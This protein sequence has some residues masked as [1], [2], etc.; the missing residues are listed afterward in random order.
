M[1]EI[2][3]ILKSLHELEFLF[4]YHKHILTVN[5]CMCGN[6]MQNLKEF[7]RVYTNM[8]DLSTF[9]RKEICKMHTENIRLNKLN[10]DLTEKLLHF[11]RSDFKRY[12]SQQNINKVNNYE[13][14]LLKNTP[15][16]TTI[17]QA[18]EKTESK[19][20][21]LK[22]IANKADL[23]SSSSFA[24][25]GYGSQ[26]SHLQNAQPTRIRSSINNSTPPICRQIPL[27]RGPNVYHKEP[28]DTLEQE[29]NGSSLTSQ[30]SEFV[31]SS[32]SSSS[33]SSFSS[34]GV[35]SPVKLNVFRTEGSVF[36][37]IKAQIN[38]Q[39][40]NEYEYEW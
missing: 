22:N 27:L 20:A 32:S 33:S 34:S 18:I 4:A 21:V 38:E 1:Q 15:K 26:P 30:N 16:I 14:Q 13:T 2:S 29:N 36:K 39:D 31:I 19:L 11:T 7:Y 28:L 12:R 10:S 6:F 23:S 9:M 25:S 8:K 40:M 24:S 3:V 35:S 17:G 37:P 5:K